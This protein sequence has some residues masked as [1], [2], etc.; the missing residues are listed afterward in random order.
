[1]KSG[2]LI[3]ALVLENFPKYIFYYSSSTQPSE[4]IVTWILEEKTTNIAEN[5]IL[6]SEIE[7]YSVSEWTAVID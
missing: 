3:R 4:E 1:M 2:I 6:R 5:K 7:L